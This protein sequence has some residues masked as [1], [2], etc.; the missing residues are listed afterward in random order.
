MF[1]RFWDGVGKV[2]MGF[3][4]YVGSVF[5]VTVIA[6]MAW[7]MMRGIRA[8]MEV[9]R[10]WRSRIGRAESTVFVVDMSNT[11]VN[12]T[13]RASQHPTRRRPEYSLFPCYL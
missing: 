5:I 3:F 1:F 4:F 13:S 11:T 8:R 2:G 9:E 12:D 7:R 10:R 6:D